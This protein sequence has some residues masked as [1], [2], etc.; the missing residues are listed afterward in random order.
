MLSRLELFDSHEFFK[1]TSVPDV[2]SA[3]GFEKRKT[4]DGADEK[5]P[6]STHH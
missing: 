2:E 3:V 6:V 1:A 5:E 4:L